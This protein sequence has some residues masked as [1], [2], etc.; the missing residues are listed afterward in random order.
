MNLSEKSLQ[1]CKMGAFEQKDLVVFESVLVPIMAQF[2]E[3]AVI[4]RCQ[5]ARALNGNAAITIDGV[6]AFFCGEHGSI[7]QRATSSR[8]LMMNR[9]ALRLTGTK[10][11]SVVAAEQ[12]LRE[13]FGLDDNA[14]AE[15][16]MSIAFQ[17]RG[18]VLKARSQPTPAMVA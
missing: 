17:R 3:D 8:A 16:L 11:S 13:Q 2:G 9:R 7:A 6:V 18:G 14:V 1:A 12:C 5:M 4:E 15:V 10:P